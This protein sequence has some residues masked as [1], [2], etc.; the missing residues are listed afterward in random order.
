[1]SDVRKFTKKDIARAADLLE[2]FSWDLQQASDLLIFVESMKSVVH[3]MVEETAQQRADV[4]L[5]KQES[6]RELRDEAAGCAG[7]N[8]RVRF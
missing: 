5:Q 4:A 3:K 7:G 8:Y 1:V 2:S 6:V